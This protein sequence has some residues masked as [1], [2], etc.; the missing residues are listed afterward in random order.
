V[1]NSSYECADDR[2]RQR[3]L[4]SHHRAH[5]HDYA[6]YQHFCFKADVANTGVA[7]LNV[8]GGGAKTIKKAAGGVTTDLAD[9][10]IRAGQTVEVMYDGTNFQIQS[11]LGNAA[12]GGGGGS[13]IPA[14]TASS[15]APR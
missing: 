14:A 13:E 3:H 6:L 7:T 2:D 10:D 12:A 1:Q 9:N 15:R 8:N 11:T 4:R 5:A